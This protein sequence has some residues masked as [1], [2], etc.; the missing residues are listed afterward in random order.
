MC[1][2]PQRRQN[3][4]KSPFHPDETNKFVSSLTLCSASGSRCRFENMHFSFQMMMERLTL[5]SLWYHIKNTRQSP[6][7][8]LCPT[9]PQKKTEKLTLFQKEILIHLW[10]VSLWERFEQFSL[11]AMFCKKQL[12]LCNLEM[13][14]TTQFGQATERFSTCTQPHLTSSYGAIR[15]QE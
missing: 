12:A 10:G 5:V 9:F 7:S 4:D 8:N 3:N 11:F 14:I 6:E 2:Q 15:L 1:Y 13:M